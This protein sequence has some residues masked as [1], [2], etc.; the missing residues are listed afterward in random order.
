VVGGY[1]PDGSAGV[2]A[3]VIGYYDAGGLRFA[4]KVRAGFVP[5]SRRELLAQLVPLLTHQCPFADLPTRSKPRWGAGITPEDMREF[6]WVTPQLVA[7]VR[8]LEWTAEG[9]LRNASFLGLRPD[10][11]ALEV[12][13]EHI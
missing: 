13:R 7:Q 4:A 8:F 9:R 10:K 5:H 6:R 1:R 11:S 12:H 2:D 3:L